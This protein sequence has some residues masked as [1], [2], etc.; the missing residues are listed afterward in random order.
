[1]W[2]SDP[3][4]HGQD[5]HGSLRHGAWEIEVGKSQMVLASI[6]ISLVVFFKVA[7]AEHT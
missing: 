5:I 4:L 1:M 2:P 3:M 7:L 6:L